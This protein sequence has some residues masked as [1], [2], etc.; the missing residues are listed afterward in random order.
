MDGPLERLKAG[1]SPGADLPMAG[2]PRAAECKG[3]LGSGEAAAGADGPL[4]GASTGTPFGQSVRG[5]PLRAPTGIGGSL[6]V[7]YLATNPAF[8]GIGYARASQLWK[9]MGEN[10]Y[11]VLGGADVPALAAVVGR[12]RA[13]ALAQSWACNLAEGDVVVWLSERGFDPHLGLRRSGS[14][15][16]ARW[17]AS[18][19]TPYVLMTLAPWQRVDAAA[20]ALGFAADHPHRQVAAVEAALYRRL[21][22]GHTWTSAA[23]VET[24]VGILLD[25]GLG[26]ARGAVALALEDRAAIEVHGGYQP[27]GAHVMER[28]VADRVIAMARP[29]GT[30]D[31]L[32]GR[33]AGAI[34][35]EREL[36]DMQGPDAIV[37]NEAQRTAVAMALESPIGLILGGAGV[38][39]TTV[40]AAVHR[41]AERAGMAVVQM[42]LSGR[43]AM[44]M[45]EATS[46]PARTIAGFL[47]ACGK[48]ELRTGPGCVVVVDEASMLDLPLLYS[49]L[50]HLGDGCRLIMVG[51]PSQLPPISFG[52]TFH[53]FA[54][55]CSLPPRRYPGS[56]SSRCTGKRRKRASPPSPTRFGW[57]M[58][59][60]FLH[61][62]RGFGVGYPSSN[63]DPSGPPTP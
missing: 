59:R 23:K 42:A 21:G 8:E 62:N 4:H 36:G 52:L 13:E 39:K 45:R 48:G 32:A 18:K 27:V 47:R 54:S 2:S 7:R 34:A 25:V 15:A 10:L 58:F 14:G 9:E 35:A 20:R 55:T 16:R 19:R 53:L 17:S 61:G 28:F 49:I 37:L 1:R 60:T 63:A 38:G 29:T 22:R 33:R 11:R 30:D 40:L 56:N 41:A 51:D 44:R 6:I 12:D 24:D 5:A 43:A 46:R 26:K 3:R 57:A 31:L 50:R